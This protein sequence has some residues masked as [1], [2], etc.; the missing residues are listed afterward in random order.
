MSRMYES[1]LHN[2][3]F[4]VN[5]TL[6]YFQFRPWVR[7]PYASCLETFKKTLSTRIV[8]WPSL[9]FFSSEGEEENLWPRERNDAQTAAEWKCKVVSWVAFSTPIR[10]WYFIEVKSLV[11][12][13]DETQYFPRLWRTSYEG[14]VGNWNKLDIKLEWIK[15]V[16]DVLEWSPQ[17]WTDSKEDCA[18]DARRLNSFS[19]LSPSNESPVM[20]C[21]ISHYKF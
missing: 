5:I 1:P 12:I 6:Y 7:R 13:G 8:K 21:N 20:S 4:N 11:E 14:P 19:T 3:Q 17:D 18:V 16:F 15:H 10:K 9:L 2:A